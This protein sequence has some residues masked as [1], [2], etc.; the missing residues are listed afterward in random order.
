M[1]SLKRITL[2]L[3][4]LMLTVTAKAENV[5][6]S[7]STSFAGTSYAA[8]TDITKNDGWT[9]A[10][11][12][13]ETTAAGRFD[14]TA[15][16]RI[17]T[18]TTATAVLGHITS[19]EKTGGVGLV[20]F[21][22]KSQSGSASNPDWEIAVQTSEDGETFTTE[23][24]IFLKPT[25]TTNANYV[26]FHKYI[27][28]PNAK[29]VRLELQKKTAQAVVNVDEIVITDCGINLEINPDGLMP[30]KEVNFNGVVAFPVNTTG[31]SSELNLDFKA[32]TT[33]FNFDQLSN[34]LADLSIDGLKINFNSATP[35]I[36]ST[37]L[38]VYNDQ[39]PKLFFPITIAALDRNI[40]QD[41][42]GT[43]WKTAA[44]ETYSNNGWDV[45]NGCV[46][47]SKTSA[48]PFMY[49]GDKF[50]YLCEYLVTPEKLGGVGYISFMH[51]TEAWD[52]SL[53]VE[54]YIS[55]DKSDDNAWTLV[56]NFQSESTVYTKCLIP[57]NNANAKYVKIKVIGATATNP[58]SRLLM[59]NLIVTANDGKAIPE[60][61]ATNAYITATDE[62]P[63]SGFVKLNLSN[64]TSDLTVETANSQ[65]TLGATTIEQAEANGVY[66]LPISFTGT[67]DFFNGTVTI[68]GGGLFLPVT[69]PVA[70]YKE[71]ESL[72]ANFDEAKW[73]EGTGTTST[74]G[75]HYTATGW[76]VINGSRDTNN[77][78]GSSGADINMAKGGFLITPP[79]SS[80]IGSIQFY[81]KLNK[82]NN[83]IG[84]IYTSIDG[85]NWTKKTEIPIVDAGNHAR[86]DVIINDQTAKF[87]RIE[88]TTPSNTINPCYVDNITVTKCN[89]VIS[90]VKLENSVSASAELNTEKIVT[91][92]LRGVAIKS[93]IT[94]EVAEPFSFAGE[95]SI[96]VA[97]EDINDKV[98]DLNVKYAPTEGVYH[99]S[100]ILITGDDFRI[101]PSYSIEGFVLEDFLYA[102][103]ETGSA[104]PVI[105]E[106]GNNSGIFNGWFIYQG[107]R[108]GTGYANGRSAVNLN[109]TKTSEN[110]RIVSPPKINGVGSIQF[111]YKSN[112][113]L[114]ANIVVNTY[115]TK[116]GEPTKI[117]EFEVK[118]AEYKLFK[119]AVNDPNAL[120]VEL[121]VLKPTEGNARAIYIDDFA[122]SACNKSIPAV[123]MPEM[124]YMAA[125][126][127]EEQTIPFEITLDALNKPDSL[128]MV[129][130]ESSN[131][132]FAITPIKITPETDKTVV[133][134]EIKYTPANGSAYVDAKLT[135]TGKGMLYPLSIPV[136]ANV[137]KSN[138]TQNFNATGWSTSTS[139]FALEGWYIKNGKRNSS[140]KFLKGGSGGSLALAVTAHKTGSV[141][142]PAKLGGI[143]EIS[144][145]YY[146]M[147]VAMKLYVET[148]PDGIVWT[149]RDSLVFTANNN[150]STV[151]D[152]SLVLNDPDARRLRL[153]TSNNVAA[154]DQSFYIDHISIVSM[155][156]LRQIG[157]VEEMTTNTLPTI[158]VTLAGHLDS[159]AAVKMSGGE[160]SN[161][162]LSVDSIAAENLA[163]DVEFILNATLV[164]NTSGVYQESIL[165]V[166]E[167]AGI[168]ISIPLKVTY[169]KPYLELVGTVDDVTT[170][171][172][173]VN[174]PVTVKGLIVGNIDITLSGA[175]AD[176]F[177]LEKNEITAE[178]LAEGN[179]SFNVTFN[180]VDESG[181][182]VANIAFGDILNVPLK[183]TYNK[184]YVELVAAVGDITTYSLPLSFPLI[185]KGLITETVNIT[186]TGDAADKFTL[187]KTTITPA[188]FEAGNVFLTFT[189]NNVTESGVYEATVKVGDFLDIPLKVT[190]KKPHMELV[191]TVDELTTSTLP[192][193][194]PITVK[195]FSPADITISHTGAAADKFTLSKT[196]ITTAELEAGNVSFDLTFNGVNQSG[197]YEATVK[198]GNFLT[199]PV[200]VTYNKPYMELVGT[201]DE[202]TTST[203]PATIPVTVKGLIVENQTVSLTGA[204][205]DKFTLSKTTIT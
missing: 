169:N 205:A 111:L 35:G 181:E 156:Y 125:L 1:K 17:K 94:I 139:T 87:A 173:P 159:K 203:L 60:V 90:D 163:D 121:V 145:S 102:N 81:V 162:T 68:S 84:K 89:E 57:V 16:C 142:S 177:S 6:Q 146:N 148:S 178:E 126:A 202:V 109:P 3:F 137:L 31:L 79:L 192:L 134:G 106:M 42:E 179:V 113:S 188:E 95:Q 63:D 160:S 73:A 13:R 118:N 67:T 191:G 154:T 37:I 129:F 23:E 9:Y 26:R 64:I 18:A 182:Y 184:P 47:T 189:F 70:F 86:H 74:I 80:G 59:D 196:T 21:W 69:L 82:G 61:E 133:N 77:K 155:P 127:G 135:V 71:Q 50:F 112:N 75:I 167:D 166:N 55:E 46:N 36:F 150:G 88:I 161:F 204:A 48:I 14:G 103:F 66:N 20:S 53:G 76:K 180:G 15:A 39:L 171:T 44:N 176:K 195:G 97:P 138:F 101:A 52:A 28:K 141:T 91:V 33:N 41:F 172:L 116:G 157:V 22:C 199:I 27:G 115:K 152:Y 34:S 201:V 151:E 114:D 43:G 132:S 11:L 197:V 58:V 56:K 174:I 8:S 12:M 165:I 25:Q 107:A 122:V 143:K 2:F 54:V 30:G 4:L 98:Y 105:P 32:T 38:T 10:D 120:F 108:T 164:A 92:K 158:P 78:M 19:P 5:S 93:P 185:L 168:N 117:D 194:I 45:V 136:V 128:G 198:V 85:I 99:T 110:S 149:K 104:F 187:S 100:S 186:L 147:A 123:I 124:F 170:S 49:A 72:F 62:L 24:T 119:I 51:R 130:L 144:F 140:T 29:Y 7:F 65:F 190:Y 83:V 131:N 175:N 40:A 183:V 200:K 96:I 193:T 153:S